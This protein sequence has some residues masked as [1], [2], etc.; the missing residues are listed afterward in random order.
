MRN[1]TLLLGL[2]AT[3]LLLM[4]GPA[5]QANLISD[6]G[7]ELGLTAGPNTFAIVPTGDPLGAWTVIGEKQVAML[8]TPFD[9]TG[10]PPFEG[11]EVLHLGEFR[12]NN[13]VMQS[14]PTAVGVEYQLHFSGIGWAGE[15]ATV[16]VE[17]GDLVTDVAQIPSEWTTHS[18]TFTATDSTSTLI[19]QNE[20]SAGPGENP[21]AVTIDAVSVVPEPTTLALLGCGILAAAA[22]RRRRS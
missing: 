19:L 10:V 22:T 14:F 2:V 9:A 12:S 7:F 1:H 13:G 20:T 6:G 16:H 21:G 17:V 3:V 4:I 8:G 15:P 11:D 18:L 5:A